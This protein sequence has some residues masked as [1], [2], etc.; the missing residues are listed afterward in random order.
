LFFVAFYPALTA[1]RL[2]GAS[3]LNDEGGCFYAAFPQLLHG[4]VFL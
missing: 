3:L 4:G 2:E 1:A